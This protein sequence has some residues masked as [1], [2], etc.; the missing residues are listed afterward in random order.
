[1]SFRPA[2]TG[3]VYNRGSVPKYEADGLNRALRKLVND[4]TDDHLLS[5]LLH[6][7]EG[8]VAS[9]SSSQPERSFHPVVLSLNAA[10][11]RWCRVA[12]GDGGLAGEAAGHQVGH[13]EMDHGFGAVRMGLVVARQAAVQHQ[14][15]I[16]PLHRPALR[17][18]GESPGPG[19][20]LDDFEVDPE[21]G[22]VLDE[23]LAVAAVDPDLAQAGMVGGSLVQEGFPGGGV[24]DAGRG[25][26][27][28]QQQAEGVGDDAALTAHDLLAR[29]DAL[30]P[31]GNGGGG[32]DALR[33]DH[34]GRRVA[35]LAFLLAYQLP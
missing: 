12:P 31:G 26:Q 17:D 3:G 25:D 20:A 23:V 21:D 33:V 29:V 5:A 15:A 32:L 1:M 11:M 28:R 19:R 27:H 7:A 22:G 34:T 10:L 4:A 9:R 6:F 13:G 14:P 8:R 2:D 18:R 35:F 16:R 30:R 24:P